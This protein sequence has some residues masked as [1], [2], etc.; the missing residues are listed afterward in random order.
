M[1]PA[2]TP[3]FLGQFL[4][5]LLLGTGGFTALMALIMTLHQRWTDPHRDE[6]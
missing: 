4:N 1:S 3:D 5:L 2:D 6:L